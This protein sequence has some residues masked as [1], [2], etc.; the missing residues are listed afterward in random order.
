MKCSQYQFTPLEQYIHDLYQHLSIAKPY[1]LDMIDIASKLNIW[2]HFADIRS[3]AIDRNGIYSII[4]D[5]RLTKQQQWQDFGHELCH[6]LRHSGNQV[7][8]PES[9]VQLQEAQATNFALHF[10][11]PTFMLLNLELPYTENEI[12][13]FLSETFCVEPIFAK[14]RWERFEQQ[15][16][17]Y[18]FYE[19]L[20]KQTLSLVAE[21]TLSREAREDIIM[22]D[23]PDPLLEYLKT[24]KGSFFIHDYESLTYEEK[25][26]MIQHIQTMEQKLVH[27]KG[28]TSNTLR[29]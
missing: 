3:T 20:S 14:K 7:M 25:K 27:S 15:W 11:V 13:Y 6:L 5:R 19:S 9:M 10:C 2:L 28:K 1:Q 21:S 12:I 8:L 26:E 29:K 17:S 24:H 22:N 4:I 23:R 16:T 18:Q